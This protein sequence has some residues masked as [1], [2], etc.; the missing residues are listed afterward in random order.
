[1][2]LT[3]CVSSLTRE[4]SR[5]LGNAHAVPR[6]LACFELEGVLIGIFEE[7]EWLIVLGLG[8]FL[9][10]RGTA[11]RRWRLGGVKGRTAFR[12]SLY[13]RFLAM[14]RRS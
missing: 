1:M 7:D 3:F 14:P 6:P 13:L 5:I 11:F 10:S 4:F 2:P 9:S 8:S 12:L